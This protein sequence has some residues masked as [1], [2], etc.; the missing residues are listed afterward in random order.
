MTIRPF[1]VAAPEV[2]EQLNIIPAWLP[3]D[4]FVELRSMYNWRWRIKRRVGNSFLARIVTSGA[5]DTPNNLPVMGLRTWNRSTDMTDQTIGFDTIKSNLLVT[6]GTSQTF[7][8][9]NFFAPTPPSA[10]PPGEQFSW[11]GTNIQFFDTRNYQNAFFATNGKA[12][13]HAKQITTITKGVSTILDVGT[14]APFAVGDPVFVTGITSTVAADDLSNLNDHSFTI[15]A[16]AATTITIPFDSSLLAGVLSGGTA[17]MLNHSA[18]ATEDGIRWYANDANVKGWINYN[19]PIDG[20]NVLKGAT[21]VTTYKG[22][23]LFFNTIEGPRTGVTTTLHPQRVRFSQRGTCFYSDPVPAFQSADGLAFRGDIPGRGGFIDASTNEEIRGVEFVRDVLIVFFDFSTYRLTF[24]GDPATPF[25]W[26][27]I[28]TEFGSRS[29]FSTIP[30]DRGVLAVGS[31]G[32]ISADGNNV[33]RIDLAIP[34]QV[35]EFQSQEDGNDRVYGAR[36]YINELVYWTL[37]NKSLGESFYSSVDMFPNQLLVFN[38]R[39]DTYSV[40]DDSYTCFGQFY[41]FLGVLWDTADMNWE[42]A[43]FTWDYGLKVADSPQ[44]IA[45]TPQGY[46]MILN[47]AGLNE[48]SMQVS[49]ITQASEAVVTTVAPHNVMPDGFV[50][51]NDVL[52]M[53]QINGLV[54]EV[55]I[56]STTSFRCLDIDSTSFSAHTANSGTIALVPNFT[57]LTKRFNPFLKEGKGVILRYIDFYVD[58]VEGGQISID[59]FTDENS[60]TPANQGLAGQFSQTVLPLDA[61]AKTNLGV[62]RT[63]VRFQCAARGQFVQVKGK[64]SK[65]QLLDNDINA[66]DFVMHAMILHMGPSGRI[67]K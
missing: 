21:I 9:I 41:N 52:G 35:Y 57:F 13:F 42:D 25:Q 67:Y 46:V 14:A 63:W 65:P 66:V 30:F 15:S 48:G 20:A 47:E 38:Y 37:V 8:D 50:Q 58:Y 45:G 33:Q 12:G 11:S 40:F 34:D 51:F 39:Q 3:D 5:P 22:R 24:T 60:S 29:P 23:L 19:P 44:L 17:F 16:T 4:A 62:S 26:D 10:A 53:T 36:D 61:K 18:G 2:G 49:T 31:R 6:T 55:D 59:I 32:I 27:L 54:S 1:L 28:N 43:D 64:L 7:T 56:I